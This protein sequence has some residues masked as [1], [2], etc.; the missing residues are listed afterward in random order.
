M[1]G[2]SE[3]FGIYCI[4]FEKPIAFVLALIRVSHRRSFWRVIAS[5][6]AKCTV[7]YESKELC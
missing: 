1:I 3:S 7:V 6:Q 5:R 4:F 2:L